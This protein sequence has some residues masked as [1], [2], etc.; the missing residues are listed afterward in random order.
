MLD[1]KQ[2]LSRVEKLELPPLARGTVGPDPRADGP[3][4]ITP[5]GAGNR[6]D[7]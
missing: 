7:P 2:A 5:A 4:G 3:Q 6:G 1:F